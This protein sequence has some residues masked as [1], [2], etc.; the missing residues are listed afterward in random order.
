MH[1]INLLLREFAQLC[2]WFPSV[3]Y[4]PLNDVCSEDIWTMLDWSQED[5]LN[6]KEYTFVC[7]G[8]ELMKDVVL[9]FRLIDLVVYP[10]YY[11]KYFY[12]LM[13]T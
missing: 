1:V 10:N 4:Y 6:R 7:M 3:E 13:I 11:G 2:P 5:R 9:A 8:H 12:L